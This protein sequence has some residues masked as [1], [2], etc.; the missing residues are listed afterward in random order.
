MKMKKIKED[1]LKIAQKASIL[2]KS[3][4]CAIRYYYEIFK[5]AFVYKKHDCLYHGYF[6]G[7][8]SSCTASWLHNTDPIRS[9]AATQR[10][11]TSYW[12]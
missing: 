4:L 6:E 11:V 1:T 7:P 5:D 12:V 10:V 8:T 2:W 3:E 9:A